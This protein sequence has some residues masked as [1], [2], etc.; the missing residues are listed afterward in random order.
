MGLRSA[1]VSSYYAAP[2]LLQSKK[3]LI[4][5]ISAYGAV[6]YNLDPAYGATKAGLDKMTWDMAQDFKPH[7]VAVVSIWP[8]V[9][10]TEM[11]VSFISQLPEDHEV[12]KLLETADIHLVHQQNR[13]LIF[14]NLYCFI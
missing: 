4:A 3:A 9:V 11:M 1:Y 13:A 8:S 14:T 12:H 6:H 5:N 10:T 2:L 7:E